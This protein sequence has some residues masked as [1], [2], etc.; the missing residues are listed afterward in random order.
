VL[1]IRER[2]GAELMLR[3]LFE[4]PTVAQLSHK[5]EEAVFKMISTMGEDEVR[6]RLTH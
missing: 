3:D 4:G 2:F 6:R 5:V 1:N